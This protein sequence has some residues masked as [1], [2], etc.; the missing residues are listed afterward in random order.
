MSG[1]L[2]RTRM[3]GVA[4]VKGELSIDPV[5]LTIWTDVA[6]GSSIPA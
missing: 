4:Q 3:L 1:P 6:N 2:R 5:A